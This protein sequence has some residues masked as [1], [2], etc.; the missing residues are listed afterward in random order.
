MR[1]IAK[2]FEP[3]EQFENAVKELS[4]AMFEINSQFERVEWLA[5][6]VREQYAQMQQAAGR[7]ELL[8][9]AEAAEAL[10][11]KQTQLR[12]LRLE[13]HLPYIAFGNKPRYTEDHLREIAQ[14]L[15]VRKRRPSMQKAA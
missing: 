7:F 13:L 1:K 11:I 4:A 2:Q 9:E 14:I 5:G 15:E 8:T 10:K 12:D 3:S 6:K